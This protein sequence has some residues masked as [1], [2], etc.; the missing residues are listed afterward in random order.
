MR[1]SAESDLEQRTIDW[2]GS[3]LGLAVGP[4]NPGAA[5][6]AASV[7]PDAPAVATPDSSIESIVAVE[8]DTA[9]PTDLEIYA[10]RWVEAGV[11]PI[12]SAASSEFAR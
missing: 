3:S 6:L 1:L 5:I 11:A 12:A 2:P 4:L 7:D 9:G 8:L 10:G